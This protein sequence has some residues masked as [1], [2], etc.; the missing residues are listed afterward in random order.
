MRP[1]ASAYASFASDR[2]HT[3]PAAPPARPQ[4]E[5]RGSTQA[6]RLDPG[7]P[8]APARRGGVRGRN[9][10]LSTGALLGSAL[11]EVA[12]SWAPPGPTRR[13]KKLTSMPAAK[14]SPACSG[15]ADEPNPPVDR[16]DRDRPDRG[17]PVPRADE[18]DD[19]ARAGPRGRARVRARALARDLVVAA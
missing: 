12:V 18:P 11:A 16:H 5:G 9:A 14:G 2:P 15:R 3:D 19:R 4:D 6:P 17:R 10:V 1:S 13:P 7:N 8:H